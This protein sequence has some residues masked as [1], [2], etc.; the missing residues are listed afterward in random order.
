MKGVVKND[1]LI[2]IIYGDVNGVE[3]PHT[4]ISYLRYDPNNNKVIDIREL[5]QPYTF[6][7][8]KY[9]IKHIVQIDKN[10]QPLEC[11]WNDE[12]IFDKS[13]NQWRVKTESE[14][15]SELKQ[16]AQKRLVQY[17]KQ[18]LQKILDEYS[19][20]DLSDVQL[21]ANQ[22]DTEAQAILSWYQAYDDLVWSYID[23]DLEAFTSVDGLLA[24]DMKNIEEQIYQQSIEQNPLP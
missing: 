15:I 5:P 3:I 12:L 6:Y 24:I 19:Y 8:D 20:I 2:S 23:N 16:E 11:N 18:R 10:W 13:I 1:L 7:I 17:E 14:K 21:Y 9:G 4:D 22:N